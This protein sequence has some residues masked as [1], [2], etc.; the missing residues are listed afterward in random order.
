MRKWV[1]SLMVLAFLVTGS[2]GIYARPHNRFGDGPPGRYYGPPGP[3]VRRSEKN[4]AAYVIHRTATTIS[5]AQRAA[6]RGRRYEG[7]GMAIAHQRKARNLYWEGAYRLA[8]YHSL[9]AR[10]LAFQV[11]AINRQRPLRDYYFDDREEYY[12]QSAPKGNK[13]DI[14]IDSVKVLGKGDAL[15]RLHF[16]LDIDQ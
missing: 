10:D 13:I 9:R 6:E 1:I 12:V 7:L 8:I 14:S 5:N 4:D 3:P 2:I 11:V 15:V 16:G